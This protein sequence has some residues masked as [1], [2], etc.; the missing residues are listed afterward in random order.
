[1]DGWQEMLL[2]DEFAIGKVLPNL[3]CFLLGFL[4]SVVHRKK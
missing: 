2:D 1:M 4:C 3:L